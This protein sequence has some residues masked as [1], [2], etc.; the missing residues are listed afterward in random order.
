MGDRLG[1]P[2][3]WGRMPEPVDEALRKFG[4]PRKHLRQRVE[5]RLGSP[6][7]AAQAPRDASEEILE[8]LP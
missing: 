6:H 8:N 5:D 2:Y 1:S 4:C 3:V 7:G